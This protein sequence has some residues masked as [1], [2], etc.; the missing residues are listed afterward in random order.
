MPQ[1][2]FCGEIL[3][4][5]PPCP[6]KQVIISLGF[7]LNSLL[8][9]SIE[10]AAFGVLFRGCPV[11]VWFKGTKTTPFK[12]THTQI[13][14]QIPFCV[15]TP[16]STFCFRVPFT[17]NSASP[18]AVWFGLVVS[19]PFSFNQ[20]LK[21]DQQSFPELW[22]SFWSLFKTTKQNKN[23]HTHPTGTL[24]ISRARFHPWPLPLSRTARRQLEAQAVVVFSG[25]SE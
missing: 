15:V 7:P 3:E 22:F 19:L 11:K 4:L 10:T 24:V 14:S 23:T 25:D 20:R 13:M 16:A 18:L 21:Q 12:Q 1:A 9:V 17:G 5:V 6:S 2:V 8:V